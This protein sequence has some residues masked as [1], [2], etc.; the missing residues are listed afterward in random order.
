MEE[1]DVRHLA[2]V[3]HLKRE[4][5]NKQ[6]EKDND[7]M[8]LMTYITAI[9]LFASTVLAQTSD[10]SMYKLAETFEKGGDLEKAGAI[11]Y[12]LWGKNP[13][14][15]DYFRGI[16]RTYK[17][18]NKFKDLLLVIKR[19]ISLREST[20]SLALYAEI[21]WRTGDS[22]KAGEAWEAARMLKP[23]S[24]Q[25][26]KDIAESQ[27][28][29]RLFEKAVQTLEEGRSEIDN[30]HLFADLLS[31]LYIAKG[32]Y[33]KGTREVL[34]IFTQSYNLSQTQGRLAAMM[35][36]ENAVA[37]VE[38]KLEEMKSAYSNNINFLRLHAWFFRSIGRHEKAFEIFKEIDEMANAKGRELYRFAY[39]SQ[40]DGYLEIALK[41]FEYIIDNF[42]NKSQKL[43]ALYGYIRTLEE[44][45][46]LE[47]SIGSEQVM[48]V[49][50][51]YASV[52]EEFPRTSTA[53][54]CNYRMAV[55]YLNQLQDRQKAKEELL[56]MIEEYPRHGVTADASILLGEIYLAENKN[57]EARKTFSGVVN[58]FGRS[59][60]EQLH[61]AQYNL[62]MLEYYE[63][64]I[65]T[66]AEY[67]SQLSQ[68]S[69][70][71]IAN[72]AL[73]RSIL[74]SLNQSEKDA[75]KIYAKAE[76]H[77]YR[78]NYDNAEN[79]FR[80]ARESAPQSDLAERTYLEN[81]EIYAVRGKYSDA[82]NILD[83][84][85]KAYP[86]TIYG[87]IALM[88]QGDYFL[89]MNQEDN[90]IKKYTEILS[91]YP[92]SIY[93]KEARDKIRALRDGKTS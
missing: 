2:D 45:M 41:S 24:Q 74:I 90:A 84:L 21:L 13:A 12:E 34:N 92:S 67:F 77:K 83:E 44:K 30:I 18:L 60:T 39:D 49:I 80:S 46:M 86:N 38:K 5:K 17:G 15:D 35:I 31:Q 68:Q 56:K 53:A 7:D 36:N 47:D 89:E 81:A 73:D 55:L 20:K 88:M 58:T 22:K 25:T 4:V 66:A 32:D 82:V 91:E 43:N 16:V 8:R 87:D 52:I 65:D 11:Y 26:Y 28:T 37:H 40:R 71:D 23:K 93:L 27:I 3:G 79:L 54:D 59:M 42:D 62:A 70:S 63:G 51:R 33:E 1:K 19:Y 76:L 6:M 9:F 48:K 10:R 50:K 14:N 75:L 78:K 57:E 72:D 85:F 29:L 64:N 69:N 61:K